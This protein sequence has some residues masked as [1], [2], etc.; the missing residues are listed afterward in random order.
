MQ[1]RKSK[2]INI[3]KS[4][5]L[6]FKRPKPNNIYYC[7]NPKG[8][9]L[10]TRLCLGLSC[11]PEHKFK[12]SFQDCLDPFCFSSNEIETSTHERMILL[13][14]IK[15]INCS[16]LEFSN[17]VVTKILLFRDNTLSDSNTFNL[18]STID[19][20]VYTKRLL[21]NSQIINKKNYL[22]FQLASYSSVFVTI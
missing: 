21:F 10:S 3:F 8:I 14:K 6:K 4:D 15:S 18:N 13:N 16:I 2:S 9:R 22:A 5:I 1:I 12:P 11:L 7:H 19:Y 20:I 17:A